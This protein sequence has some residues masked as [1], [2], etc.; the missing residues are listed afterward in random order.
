MQKA[1]AEANTMI[2]RTP[3]GFRYSLNAACTVMRTAEQLQDGLRHTVQAE[4]DSLA[5]ATVCLGAAELPD[6]ATPIAELCQPGSDVLD[7]R[8]LMPPASCSDTSS[9]TQL[10]ASC[11]QK[12]SRVT[13][14]GQ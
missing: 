8:I 1:L 5:A 11:P 3:A 12:Y 7:A 13:A 14:E 4:E 10:P 2:H 9:G 6:A